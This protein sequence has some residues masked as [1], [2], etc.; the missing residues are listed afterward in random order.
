MLKKIPAKHLTIGMHLHALCGSWMKSPFWRSKFIV[1]EQSDILLILNSGIAEVWIDVEKGIDMTTIEPEEV[2]EEQNLVKTVEVAP[3]PKTRQP[4]ISKRVSMAEEMQRAEQICDSSTSAV[5]SMFKEARMG[6]A[7]SVEAAGEVVEEISASV[8]RNPS[9]LINLA[10]LK[11]ADDYTY[12][13]SVAVCALMVALSRQLH[14]DEAQT[15]QA[16][17]G[18]LLHDLGKA[19]MPT[20]VLNKPGKLTDQE[21]AVMKSHPREGHRILQEGGIVGEVPLD[22]CLHH[23][24]KIDGSGY[25]FALKGDEISLYAKMAAVCDVYDAITSNR[26]YK[27]GWGPAESIVKMTEWSKGHFDEHIF[28]SFVRCIGIYPVGTL[29]GLSS[30]RLGVVIEQSEKSLLTPKVK[31]FF[32]TKRKEYVPP[33]VIDLSRSGNMD[34]IASLENAK[35]WGIKKMDHFWAA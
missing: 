33:E 17:L 18:G 15:R 6:K 1:T 12:M 34:R 11:S 26:P 35:K 23:H 20:C 30:G 24:E 27:M 3:M 28:Q 13:H 2:V 10:R 22:V 19:V 8:M 16:G 31:V 5:K 4:E 9:A 14:L 25:P 7:I 29:V 21:F 32:S